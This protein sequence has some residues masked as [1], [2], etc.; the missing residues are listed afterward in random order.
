MLD[1][2]HFYIK[3]MVSFL[4]LLFLLLTFIAYEK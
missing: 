4:L 2:A 3:G 1:P